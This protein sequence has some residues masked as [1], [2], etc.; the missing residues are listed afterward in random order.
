MPSVSVI[1]TA[2]VHTPRSVDQAWCSMMARSWSVSQDRSVA[3]AVPVPEPDTEMPVVADDDAGIDLARLCDADVA[4]ATGS[5]SPSSGVRRSFRATVGALQ[6][7]GSAV[8]DAAPVGTPAGASSAQVSVTTGSSATV[9]PLL[10][11]RAA[12]RR[13]AAMRKPATPVARTEGVR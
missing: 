2:G 4:P 11:R 10:S 12:A 13:A 9:R 8:G 1:R 5:A 3:Q 6:P 7:V